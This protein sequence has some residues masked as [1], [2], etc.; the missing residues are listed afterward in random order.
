MSPCYFVTGASGVVGSAFVGHLLRETDATVAVVLRPRR[1]VAP[2]ARLDGLFRFWDLGRLER[3]ARARVRVLVGDTEAPQLGLAEADWGW[4]T[5]HATHVVHAAALVKMNL[6]LEAARRAAVSSIEGVVAFG[7][8]ARAHQL[9]KIEVVSTV[10]VGGRRAAPLEEAWLDSPREFHN[11]YE[12]AKA[13][14]EKVTR[15]ALDDGLPLTVVRPSMVVGDSRSGR[16]IAPQIF[17]S[18]CGFLTGRQ[19]HGFFPPL[20]RA[21]LD[22]VPVDWLAR[23][24]LTSSRTP[25]WAGEVLHACSADQAVPLERLRELVQRIAR[26][27]GHRVLYRA[28]LPLEAFRKASEWAGRWGGTRGKKSAALLEILLAYLEDDQRFENHRTVALA[29]RAGLPLPAPESYLGAVLWEL[30]DRAP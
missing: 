15:Q 3:A 8:E 1:G 27:R 29:A 18:L 25:A 9:Q 13:E 30:F 22:V 24:L 10:G 16:A 11:T 6:P 2:A 20:H 14:A 12:A 17:T 19:V 23:L 5:R 28:T 26:A 21:R 7:R 4:A